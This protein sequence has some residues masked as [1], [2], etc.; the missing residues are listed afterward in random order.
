MAMSGEQGRRE[1]VGLVKILQFLAA[2]RLCTVA[3]LSS[4]GASLRSRC[5]LKGYI[6]MR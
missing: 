6:W 2:I 5:C 3:R 1:I 4:N